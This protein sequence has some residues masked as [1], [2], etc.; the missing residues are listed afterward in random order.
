MGGGP[1]SR[2]RVTGGSTPSPIA[3]HATGST[4]GSAANAMNEPLRTRR[5]IG[6]EDRSGHVS[7][8]RKCAEAA[9]RSLLVLCRPVSTTALDIFLAATRAEPPTQV[10]RI[11]S[12]YSKFS[13]LI[14]IL[15]PRKWEYQ[16]TMTVEIECLCGAIRVQLDGE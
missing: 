10:G 12:G 14:G 1:A 4:Q 9:R 16:R 11:A 5:I 13:P 3:K 8:W 7:A 2:S 6:C 15:E